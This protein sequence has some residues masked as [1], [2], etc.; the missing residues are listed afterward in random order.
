VK[1]LVVSDIHGNWPALEAVLKYAR[2]YEKILFIGDAVGYYPDADRVVTWLREN[3][4][5]GVM[6]NHDQWLVEMKRAVDGPVMEILAWQRER[7]APAN[8]EWLSALPW[9]LEVDGAHLVHGSPVDPLAYLEEVHEAKA[10]F[11]KVDHRWIFIGHS[12]VAGAFQIIP[13]EP[14]PWIR[15]QRYANGGELILAPRSRVI[16]N[17]GAVGQPRDGVTGA[18]YAIWDSTEGSIEYFRPK[19]N[20]EEVLARVHH[21]NFPMWLYERLV[22]GK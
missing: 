8:L 11:E 19:Y 1:Y 7:I 2:G 15:F 12:H 9:T 21:E 20:L 18:A 17:P 14:E 10:G 3:G 22:L 4:A 16:V 6:G 5:I 13:A